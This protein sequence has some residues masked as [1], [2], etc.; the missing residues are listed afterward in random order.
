LNA[1]AILLIVGAIAAIAV[2]GAIIAGLIAVAKSAGA[3]AEM[4]APERHRLRRLVEARDRLKQAV[5]GLPMELRPVGLDAMAQAQAMMEEAEKA[6]KRRAA[7][8]GL[9]D[10]ARRLGIEIERQ[11]KAGASLDTLDSLM[12][13]QVKLKA[14]AAQIETLDADIDEAAMDLDALAARFLAAGAS[15]S[16]TAEDADLSGLR[17]RLN[18]VHNSLDEVE[19]FLNQKS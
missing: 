19:E 10:S 13:R 9:A 3:R 5:D 16:L 6:M 15:E 17:H 8:R 2:G 4:A 12:S 7:L 1:A 11:T 18:S 14:A